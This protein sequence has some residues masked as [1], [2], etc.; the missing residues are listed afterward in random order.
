MKIQ[1]LKKSISYLWLLLGLLLLI[2][3]LKNSHADESG[4]TIISQD[5]L[6]SY[7]YNITYAIRVDKDNAA[8]MR[9]TGTL[10]GNNWLLTAGHMLTNSRGQVGKKTRMD[11]ETGWTS[12]LLALKAYKSIPL[13][14]LPFYI[15][16]V[17]AGFTDLAHDIALVKITEP[18][19]IDTPQVPI[20]IHSDLSKL[21]GKTVSTMGYSSYYDG[22][23]TETS[24]VISAV[25][26][27]GTLTVEMPV[28]K[29]NSGSPVY[30]DGELIGILTAIGPKDT[31]TTMGQTATVTPFTLEMKEILFDPNG[32]SALI[33]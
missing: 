28:A 14:P 25:E 13:S 18:Q 2:Y 21:L 4:R 22:D 29:E 12:H 1:N 26:E 23:Y 17:Y 16:P 27:N 33:D 31:S 30:L 15:M 10:I 5:L 19:K 24:G 9:G 32:I 3:P 8:D 20:K 7:P 6:N 11:G